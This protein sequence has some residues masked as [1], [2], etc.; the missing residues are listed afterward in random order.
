MTERLLAFYNGEVEYEEEIEKLISSL[1]INQ[2]QMNF[3]LILIICRSF[4]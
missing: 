1:V 4:I 2:S 3:F